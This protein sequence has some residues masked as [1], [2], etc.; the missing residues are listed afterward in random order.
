MQRIFLHELFS[1]Q[2]LFRVIRVNANKFLQIKFPI[3]L[4]SSLQSSPN[5]ALFKV[6]CFLQGSRALFTAETHIINNFTNRFFARFA[7]C[8]A[9]SGDFQ[10]TADVLTAAVSLNR[11][12]SHLPIPILQISFCFLLNYSRT[13]NY[14]EQKL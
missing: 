4:F 2:K 5:N 6:E 11:E 10:L 3:S 12:F 14:A 9:E 1:T 13:S 7:K 8:Y